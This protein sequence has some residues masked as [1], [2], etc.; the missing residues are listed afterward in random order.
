MSG[1]QLAGLTAYAEEMSGIQI[2]GLA[3]IS[4]GETNGIQLGT[5]NSARELP[6][7]LPVGVFNYVDRYEKH[8]VDSE[9]VMTE[10]GDFK[11]TPIYEQTSYFTS[12]QWGVINRT[13]S[14]WWIP[15]TNFGIF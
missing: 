10:S 3:N 13:A 12:W 15:I 4:L 7:G 14:G 5:V 11:E 6:N 1:S 8:Q 2:A 9:M